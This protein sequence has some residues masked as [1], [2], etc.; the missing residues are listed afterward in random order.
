MNAYSLATRVYHEDVDTFGV[1]YYANYLRYMERARTEW[2]RELG[3]DQARLL[4]EEG[5][6]FLVASANIEFRKPAL[7]D[8][9]LNVGVRIAHLG[10]VRIDLIQS[11]T[12]DDGQVV[13]EAAVKVACVNA[14]N[15]QPCA[16]PGL[17]IE[18]LKASE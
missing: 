8:D 1:V 3:V 16:I 17:I 13:C 4:D 7:F 6:I 14:K 18:E 15:R 9:T 2:L 12:R 5:I 11:I 10:R